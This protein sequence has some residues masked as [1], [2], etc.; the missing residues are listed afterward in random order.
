LHFSL[1]PEEDHFDFLFQFQFHLFY[2]FPLLTFI[3][4]PFLFSAIYFIFFPTDGGNRAMKKSKYK[5]IEL[6]R[7]PCPIDPSHS[8]YKHNLPLHSKICNVKTRQLEMKEEAFYCLDCNSGLIS[9]QNSQDSLILTEIENNE[10]NL[11]KTETAAN[12][13]NYDEESFSSV[14]DPDNLLKKIKQCFQK[15]NENG[16]LSL[17]PNIFEE[18]NKFKKLD[19][20]SNEKENGKMFDNIKVSPNSNTDTN[21]NTPS[22][23][24][25][26]RP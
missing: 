24:R 11:K 22:L 20:I 4:H 12:S 5:N 14:I 15:I 8:I 1:H 17:V 9:T 25:P 16:D 18:K 13:E 23:P 26:H 2:Y 3:F 21:T 19:V 7:I 6:E 10:N